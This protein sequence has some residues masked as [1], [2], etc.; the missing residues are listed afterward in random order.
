MRYATGTAGTKKGSKTYKKQAH[1]A[2]KTVAGCRT[3]GDYCMSLSQAAKQR[4]KLKA[5]FVDR[6]ATCQ[7]APKH[8]QDDKETGY[9]G[10]NVLHLPICSRQVSK[11]AGNPG[12]D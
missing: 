2:S 12:V 7:R 1:S 5:D 9:A 4:T 10:E 3:H 11:S 6:A 8:Q